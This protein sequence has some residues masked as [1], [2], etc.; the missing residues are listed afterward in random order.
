M[1]LDKAI[2][3][4]KEYREQY[5]GS[6]AI[7]KTCRNHGGCDWCNGNRQHKNRKREQAMKDREEENNE[8]VG[9]SMTNLLYKKGELVQ[10]DLDGE[11]IT[12]SIEII[13]RYGTFEQ[14]EE[15]SYDIYRKDNNTLYKHVR[16]SLI[17]GSV[18]MAPDDMRLV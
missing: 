16:Q 5:R 14:C 13:D 9:K 7:D 17:K 3:Y 6:K 15:P 8:E 1:S 4:G 12:G 11:V 18:G 2:E 10:F